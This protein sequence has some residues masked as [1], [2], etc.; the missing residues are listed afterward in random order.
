MTLDISVNSNEMVSIEWS[1]VEEV[2]EN[3]LSD[4]MRLSDTQYSSN[5]II[6][7]LT[8]G[9]TGPITCTATAEGRSKNS[10][11]S[12]AVLNIEGENLKYVYRSV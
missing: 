7:P 8:T 2:Y 10:N 12:E 6:S 4:T 5:L 9:H 11:S 3:P 1:G